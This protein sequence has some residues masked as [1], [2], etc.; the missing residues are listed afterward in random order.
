M[1][2]WLDRIAA[3]IGCTAFEAGEGKPPFV[4]DFDIGAAEVATPDA[5]G[6]ALEA[7]ATQAQ[8]LKAS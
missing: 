5:V 1:R 3:V 4:V 6:H 2:R 8:A 7:A